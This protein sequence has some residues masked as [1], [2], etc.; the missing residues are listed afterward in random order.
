MGYVR[1]AAL[2]AIVQ[3]A[4]PTPTYIGDA[5]RHSRQKSSVYKRS[6]GWCIQ[7]VACSR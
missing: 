7:E 5:L 1:C 4:A 3:R 2:H 6:V